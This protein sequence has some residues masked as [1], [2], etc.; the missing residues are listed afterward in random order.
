LEH[1]KRDYA[2][3]REAMHRNV[4]YLD[5][6]MIY[7]NET[8]KPLWVNFRKGEMKKIIEQEDTQH[9][10]AMHYAA[11]AGI[12]VGRENLKPIETRVGFWS[13][14]FECIKKGRIDSED[15][16]LAGRNVK[17]VTG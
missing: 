14:V 8:R 11:I 13:T 16:E 9:V 2:E 1:Q 12:R 17:H 6:F 15:L 5:G 7:S 10:D 3:L 4:V